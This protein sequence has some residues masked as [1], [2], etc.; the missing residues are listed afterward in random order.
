LNG[1]TNMAAV[2]SCANAL[3]CTSETFN[4]LAM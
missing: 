1:N 2:T 3:F 4:F